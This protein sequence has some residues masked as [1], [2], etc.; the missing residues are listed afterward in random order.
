VQLLHEAKL[1]WTKTLDGFEFDRSGVSAAQHAARRRVCGQGRTGPAGGRGW[2]RKNHLATGLCVAACRQ[3]RRVRF[4]TATG[5]TDELAGAAHANQ[6]GRTLAR[7]ERLDPICIDEPGYV[8][9]AETACEP[10]F[11]A[12]AVRAEK[13]AAIV[14]TPPMPSI[15]LRML[16]ASVPC[17]ASPLDLPLKSWS[18]PNRRN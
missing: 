5:P 14:P 15:A 8:P 2:H 16:R 11:R 4:T 9:L 13:A 18:T 7:R 1:S 17:L 6:L 3:P 12:I 10:M